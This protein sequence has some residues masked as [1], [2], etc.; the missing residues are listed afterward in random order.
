MQRR[1][2]IAGLGLILA[3]SASVSHGQTVNLPTRPS[4]PLP[5]IL[6]ATGGLLTVGVLAL[7]F[8]SQRQTP[9]V[10]PSAHTVPVAPAAPPPPQP[11]PAVK[12]PSPTNILLDTGRQKAQ[13][14]DHQEA[15]QDFSQ[16]IAQEP[17]NAEA[18]YERGVAYRRLQNYAQALADLNQA[19]LFNP[20]MGEAYYNRG[21]IR[22]K[23]K[24]YQRAVED[25]S[26][27]LE[28]NSE[29][30]E[31]YHNR[32]LARRKLGDYEGAS[33]D[34]KKALDLNPNYRYIHKEVTTHKQRMGA[35]DFY[36]RGL[37]KMEK[38]D[39]KGALEELNQA[40]R[41]D[42]DLAPCYFDRAKVRLAIGDQ[43]GAVD[44][45]RK[46]ADLFLE[47]G[48]MERCDQV[49]EVLK[50]QRFPNV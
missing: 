49:T 1:W 45:L 16:V 4:Y 43:V 18:Y 34:Y 30:A 27:A 41:M 17:D 22:F 37:V 3:L 23:V 29:A 8:L 11:S 28:F 26:K 50:M 14:G 19:I 48:D 31:F 44:D 35:D 6:I 25:Y 40:L 38:G 7:W 20:Q 46:A 47:M 33:A 39:Y 2:I 13:R 10:P 24:D 21:L 36:E 42:T 15:I 5:L 9:A 12:P 32:S